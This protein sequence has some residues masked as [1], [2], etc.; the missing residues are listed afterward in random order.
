MKNNS[1][2]VTIPSLSGIFQ[3]MPSALELNLY[4]TK[5]YIV[6]SVIKHVY[7]GTEDIILS[8]SA[9]D[10]QKNR[11][12]SNET[13]KNVELYK[14]S[15]GPKQSKTLVKKLRQPLSQIEKINKRYG[16]K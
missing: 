12:A 11:G 14:Q 13:I 5:G 4:F 7:F 8:E 16:I 10:L 1:L 3:P 2:N 6:N 9:F 15:S